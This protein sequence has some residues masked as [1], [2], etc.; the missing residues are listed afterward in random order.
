MLPKSLVIILDY[1]KRDRGHLSQSRIVTNHDSNNPIIYQ[2]LRRQFKTA[3]GV[4]K[5]LDYTYCN[6]LFLLYAASIVPP[7]K[8]SSPL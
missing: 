1:D 4:L 5:Y 3:S 8:H 2:K 7:P 6:C